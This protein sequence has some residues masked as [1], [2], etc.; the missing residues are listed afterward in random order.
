MGTISFLLASNG[1]QHTFNKDVF[2]YM[3]VTPIADALYSTIDLYFAAEGNIV[4][5]DKISLSVKSQYL[6]QSAQRFG[7]VLSSIG[8]HE[9]TIASVNL[10][11]INHHINSITYTAG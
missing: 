9:F 5:P 7:A 4:D 8:Y 3:N 6:T 11:G 1:E 2:K 10:S